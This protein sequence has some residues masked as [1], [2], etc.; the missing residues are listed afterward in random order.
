MDIDYTNIYGDMNFGFGFAGG[1]VKLLVGILLFVVIFY[2][3]MLILKVRVLKDTVDITQNSLAKI[4]IT[5]NLLISAGGAI[6][7]FILILL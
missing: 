6:L 7:A 4:V 3:F 1:A 2:A 5:A